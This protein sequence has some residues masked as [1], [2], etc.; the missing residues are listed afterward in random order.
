M[1]KELL[2]RRAFFN[3]LKDATGKSVILLSMPALLHAC[4]ESRQAR[5]AGEDFQTITEEEAIEFDAITARIIPTT[6]TAGAREAGVVFFMDAVLG[7][8][9][10]E[11]H[12]I[13]KDG[14]RELQSAA[15]QEFDV[16][17]FHLLDARQQDQLIESISD[18]S[19]FFTLRY[20]TIAG[21][22]SLPEYGGNRDFVGY[23]VI[24][25]Q[26]RGAWTQP[27]SFYDADFTERG[28]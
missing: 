24:G 4:R 18:T 5:L 19:F 7:D 16:A 3:S 17:Y 11:Q 23:D 14:L 12:A 28:E 6:E 10:E 13:L 9:R 21:M 22:F 2:S 1:Q 20:L 26:N 27:Y 15:V 8:S 25:Y